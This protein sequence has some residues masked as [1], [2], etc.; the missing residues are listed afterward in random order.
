MTLIDLESSKFIPNNPLGVLTPITTKDGSFSLRSNNYKESFHDRDGALREA[1]EKF[2]NPAQIDCYKRKPNLNIL[3]VCI[4]MGYNTGCLIEKLVNSSLQLN[5]WGLEIDKRPLKIALEN[6][7]FRETW[8]PNVLNIL[9]S[10]NSQGKWKAN[11]SQ[12]EVFWGDA[13][14]KIKSIPKDILLDVILLDAFS[15]QKCPELWTEEFLTSLS[16]RLALG[17]RIVT[18]C[19]SAAVRA[20]LKKAGLKLR[21]IQLTDSTKTTWSNGTIAI[22]DDHNQKLSEQNIQYRALSLMEEEHLLTCAAVPYRDPHQ[23]RSPETI[24][25]RRRIEQHH[26]KLESTSS[27]R[28]RWNETKST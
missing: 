5:W 20:S 23:N 8:S 11:E 19:T 9:L 7:N 28:K 26:C 14:D 4:G 17:G 3:D 10:L 1:K 2:L 16:N 18:Y 12:G 21:S 15:P 6:K 24:L 27:W 25:K 22:R 13:R